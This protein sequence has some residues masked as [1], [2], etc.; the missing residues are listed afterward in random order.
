M[1]SMNNDRWIPAAVIAIGLVLASIV[2]GGAVRDFRISD[3]YV[4]VKGLAER[5]VAADLAI[6]PINYQLAASS[7]DGLRL[8]MDQADE[9]VI[10]F[11]KLRGFSDDE[12]TRNPPRINDQWIHASGSQRPANRYTAERGLTLK[13]DRV[14]ATRSA[15]QDAAELVGQGVVLTPGW[16]QAAQFLFTGLE[17]IKPEMIAEATADARRAADQFAAD[18]DAGI[19]PIRSARQGFFSI[20]ERDPSTPE[21]KVV[22]VVTTIEYILD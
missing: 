3:R 18:S 19:G 2:I 7:L 16:G 9:S 11:L 1:D 22:R 17:D 15:L 10:A 14:E 20:N 4:E 13:T 21:V 5:E 12:I 6:W 8:A